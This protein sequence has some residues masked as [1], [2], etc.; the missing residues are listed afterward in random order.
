MFT[1]FV[2]TALGSNFFLSVS[3]TSAA[4]SFVDSVIPFSCSRGTIRECPLLSGLISRI[5]MF[6]LFSATL[7]DLDS[8]FVIAQKIQLPSRCV[9]LFCSTNVSICSNDIEL[10]CFFICAC[11]SSGKLSIWVSNCSLTFVACSSVNVII[12]IELIWL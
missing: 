6:E 10:I 2:S 8:P 1:S 4:N 9:S 12:D 7:Y 5:A 11:L 3:L